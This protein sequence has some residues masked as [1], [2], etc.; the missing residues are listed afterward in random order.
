MTISLT[1]EL[2]S[3]VQGQVAS[4]RFASSSEVIRAGLRLLGDAD[5]ERTARLESIQAWVRE[6]LDDGSQ[7]VPANEVLRE[8][9]ARASKGATGS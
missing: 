5:A 2:E 6:S 4:G 9:R 8:L 7:G 3:F 1:P